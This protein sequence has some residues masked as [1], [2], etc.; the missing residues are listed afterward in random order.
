M[1]HYLTRSNSQDSFF[2]YQ[3]S[4]T[5]PRKPKE[6]A[7]A[8]SRPK[9]YTQSWISITHDCF[10]FSLHE[11]EW[12]DLLERT[13]EAKTNSPP[14]HIK[15][16]L[17]QLPCIKG[18]D[19]PLVTRIIQAIFSEGHFGVNLYAFMTLQEAYPELIPVAQAHP[20]QIPFQ[21]DDKAFKEA[22]LF[23]TTTDRF[24]KSYPKCR[25]SLEFRYASNL[26][27]KGLEATLKKHPILKILKIDA[28]TKLTPKALTIIAE[29]CPQLEVLNLSEDGFYFTEPPHHFLTDVGLQALA[30][31]CHNLRA[32]KLKHCRKVTD[33]G[34]SPLFSA[35]PHLQEL[36][37]HYPGK[38]T[39][40]S[41]AQLKQLVVL[42]ISVMKNGFLSLNPVQEM[43]KRS[44]LRYLALASCDTTAEEIKFIAQ[45]TPT[46]EIAELMTDDCLIGLHLNLIDLYRS[47]PKLQALS[48]NR[49]PYYSNQ[50]A[51]AIKQFSPELIITKGSLGDHGRYAKLDS[52]FIKVSPWAVHG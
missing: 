42:N 6:P 21:E 31:S 15:S 7:L 19:T 11:F 38:A 46:L 44:P 27:D 40:A 17:T 36:H 32:L 18:T 41:F 45:H 2:P 37:L 4:P 26:S 10:G 52:S 22:K 5:Q 47:W 23:C 48:M 14:E 25:T 13:A 35:N 3:K 39:G 28:C 51:A 29:Y 50:T 34:L 8:S 30:K 49:L 9:S 24:L 1:L 16:Y 20:Y 12:V 43:I 33:A